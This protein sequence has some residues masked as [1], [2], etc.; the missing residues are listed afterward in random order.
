MADVLEMNLEL[1]R[2]IELAEARAGAAA[3]EA[4]KKLCP[5][6]GAAVLPIAG[7][8][9]SFLGVGSPATQAIGLGLTHEV[10]AEEFA[11]LEAFY[12][13]RNDGVRVEASPLAHASLFEHFGTGGYR[14]T[15]F[16]NVMARRISSHEKFTE[17]PEVRVKRVE[18]AEIDLWNSTVGRGFSNEALVRPDLLRLMKG[19]A[20]AD[21]VEAYLAQIDGQVAGGGT[22]VMREGVAGL[23]G[24][25]TLPAFRQRGVQTALLNT[26]LARAARCGCDL[27][28]CLAAPGSS[29]QRNIVRQGF[30]VLYTRVK[31][32]KP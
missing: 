24:A 28:A 19:F 32:E 22:L 15:E 31:F 26:R 2:R 30:Q 6:L 18:A 11:S 9:A 16:T 29:S 14:A 12:R 1:A 3:A 17:N 7:G 25:S 13:E 8:F 23:F 27:A 10:T 20:S 5:E 21:G 4:L